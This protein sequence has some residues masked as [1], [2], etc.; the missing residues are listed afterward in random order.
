[1]TKTTPYRHG[2]RRRDPRYPATIPASRDTTKRIAPEAGTA[3]SRA[4][5]YA[6][7]NVLEL[8]TAGTVLDAACRIIILDVQLAE[9]RQLN[10]QRQQRQ[11]G[12]MTQATRTSDPKLH[13]VF[14]GIQGGDEATNA[15]Y[16][17]S[18]ERPAS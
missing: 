11:P 13:R 4:T 15:L 17:L 7:P 14:A 9:T 12:A 8:V 3:A 5:N 10:T 1:M 16:T 18:D 6:S 2:P